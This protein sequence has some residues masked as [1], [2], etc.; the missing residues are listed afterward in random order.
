M[1]QVDVIRKKLLLQFNLVQ[2]KFKLEKSRELTNQDIQIALYQYSIGGL[3]NE[4]NQSQIEWIHSQVAKLT[5][6]EME[7]IRLRFWEGMSL[8]KIAQATASNPSKVY[9]TLNDIFEQLKQT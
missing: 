9:R 5:K 1:S 3:D 8:E 4:R 2:R 7:I 6:E